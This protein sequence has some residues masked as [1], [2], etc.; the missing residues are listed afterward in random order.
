VDYFVFG[1][2]NSSTIWPK[3][4][5]MSWQKTAIMTPSECFRKWPQRKKGEKA[6]HQRSKMRFWRAEVSLLKGLD[7]THGT[8]WRP[9]LSSAIWTAEKV[10]KAIRPCC[11]SQTGWTPS[12]WEDRA[13]QSSWILNEHSRALKV[14]RTRGN[15]LG[16]QIGLMRFHSK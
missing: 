3:R 8:D 16:V 12:H 9:P 10:L 15:E 7:K 13:N 4:R 6:R 1:L 14:F 5:G 11:E 2:Q